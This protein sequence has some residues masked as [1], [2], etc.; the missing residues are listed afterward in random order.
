MTGQTLFFP[1]THIT[2][3]QRDIVST[4]FQEFS[5]L[6][7]EYLESAQP[8]ALEYIE[9][10]KIHKGNEHNL[11]ALLKGTPY[12]TS[13]THIS[14]IKSQIKGVQDKEEKV[15]K[16]AKE[17]FENDLLFLTM[18]GLSD[19]Q[20]EQIDLE[21]KA[22]DKSRETL[23]KELRGIENSLEASKDEK[24][25][26]PR[27]SGEV[28][29]KERVSAWFNCMGAQ[30][31]LNP[32]GKTNLFVTTSPAV[33]D[34]FETNCSDVVNA[35]DIDQIKVHENKCKV[36]IEWQHQLKK[37]LMKA[38]KGEGNQ[39]EDLPEAMDECRR[40][41][42]IKMGLFSGGMINLLLNDSDKHMAVCLIN[43]K[44]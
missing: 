27:D 16:S 41:G 19:E 39:K 11:K 8:Q 34:Y 1:F 33:F 2:R 17:I 28:M 12:F 7:P 25:A 10:A 32:D 3:D 24:A 44:R 20:Y 5:C 38:I 31:A 40:S 14:S 21:L 26:A 42:Q 6:P 30:N 9:W 4:F 29:T 43:L 37:Y 22:L 13:D 35:L 18:A 36:K 23:L 15:Q